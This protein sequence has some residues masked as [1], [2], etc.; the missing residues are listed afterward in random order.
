MRKLTSRQAVLALIISF[1]LSTL[2]DII[3]PYEL[4][5]QS[6]FII[7]IFLTVFIAK[8]NT[9]VIVA[10][11]S[12][13]TIVLISG[14]KSRYTSWS[15]LAGNIFI[16]IIIFFI[17]LIVL[18]T[19]S[20]LKNILFDRTHMTSLFENATEGIILTNGEGRVVLVN[21]SAEQIF[22]YTQVELV[23]ELIE[24]LIPDQ[25]KPG[26]D[27]VRKRFYQHPQNRQMG[28]GRDLFGKKKDA[29]LFPVEV[30]LSYYKQNDEA[31]V[32]A[33]VVD[34]T[35]RK[36]IE[37][38]IRKQQSELEKLTEDM[39]TM[40]S[41]LEIKVDQRTQILTEALQKLEQSQ[42]ELND[43]LNKE[44]ELNEIKSRF[45]SMASHEFRTPLS[46]VL[47]S[48]SLLSKYT[49]TEEQEKRDRHIQKIKYS[50][51]H[52]NDILEDF[53]SLGKL[54]AGKVTA[55][56]EIFN[57]PEL[58]NDVVE[59]MRD[60]TETGQQILLTT[61]GNSDTISDK[62]LLRN[63]V[64][65]LVGNAIKFSEINKNIYVHAIVSADKMVIVIRDEGM[66][67]PPEDK[68]YLFSSFFRGKNAGNIQG[69]GLGLH[70]VERYVSLL[71]GSIGLET[72][73]GKG[74]TFSLTLPLSK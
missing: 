73:L 58:L 42:I 11:A 60:Q 22:G 16:L 46:T 21:P 23:G 45:V 52:L 34:I 48:A 70:I 41:D 44:K 32:I 19:K 28:V 2:L 35:A 51:K 37:L 59:E 20:L 55:S 56:F 40:N 33:F 26:H 68:P 12:G 18:Y 6:G 10:I 24:V 14:I 66:G 30:S 63:I 54:D 1:I 3:Y 7:A 15:D 53:L 43:A 64:I 65:N 72:D 38:N 36:N 5:V 71:N 17:T 27:K 49:V 61:E 39:R 8:K 29:T 4:V 57:L 25:F 13:L 69:T 9:T 50:V 74:T 62:K 67:I 47:S 31:F